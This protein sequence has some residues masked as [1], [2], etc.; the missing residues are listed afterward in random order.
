M[1]LNGDVAGLGGKSDY[2]E[3]RYASRTGRCLEVESC[4]CIDPWKP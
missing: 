1:L 4:G 2:E 3:A